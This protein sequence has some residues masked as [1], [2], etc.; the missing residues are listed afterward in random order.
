MAGLRLQRQRRRGLGLDGLAI[1][2]LR[3]ACLVH[4]EVFSDVLEGSAA[5]IVG[6]APIGPWQ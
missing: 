1:Q 4:L 2:T 6:Q 3:Y 5:A